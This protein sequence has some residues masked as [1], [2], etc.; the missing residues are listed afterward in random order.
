MNA[1]ISL[2]MIVRD[3]QATLDKCL[4][5]AKDLVDE[6]IIVDTGSVDNTINIA[7]KYTDKIFHFKWIDD[8]SAARNYS[9]EQCTCDWILWLDADD[10]LTSEDVRQIKAIDF[11]NKD[12][13]ICDYEYARDEYGNSASIVPR[14]R[15]VKRSLGIRWEEEIHEY[16]PIHYQ[17]HIPHILTPHHNKQHG[18]SERNLAILE[19]VVAKNPDKARNLYYLGKEYLDFG[20][21][22]D[23]LKYL[24]L[25][26]EKPDAFWEDVYQAYYDMAVVHFQKNDEVKFKENV[27]KSISIEERRAEPYYL[28]GLWHMNHG[29]NWSKAIHWYEAALAVKRPPELLAAYRPEYYTWLPALNLA[30]SYNSIGNLQKAYE[31]NKK[32]LEY[33]PNDERAV[34]NDKILSEALGRI[35]NQPTSNKTNGQ[36][37]RLNLG[38]GGAPLAGYTNV[39]VF[40][41]P[42]IDEVFQLDQIPYEDGTIGAIHSQHSLEHVTFDRVEKALKEWYR[43]LCPGGELILR[44]PDLALSCQGYLKA[45]QE[46]D[47]SQ[48]NYID[49]IQWYKYT[50]YGIQRSQAG[51]PDDAQVHKS[52]FSLKEMCDILESIGF[53][54][55]STEN[56][57]GWGTLSL[58][59]RAVKKVHPIK[60]G[61]I[62]PI[63]WEAAQTRIRVLNVDRWLRSKGYQSKVLQDYNDIISQNYDVTIMGKSFDEETFNSI[64]ALKQQGK[65]VYVD[66]CESLF[67]F[68]WFKE[69]LSICDKVIACSPYLAEQI[70]PV[71]PRVIIIEDAW[72]NQ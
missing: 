17:T 53:I 47:H 14:E 59:I 64:K 12:I 62:A 65:I 43:V 37:K 36:L 68:A 34:N 55:D 20:R 46:C 30:V 28:L 15:I 39:D 2:A 1:T 63:N 49:A 56:Y 10:E 27:Y 72:E 9:F 6:I 44:M 22:D 35:N 70:R 42:G 16:L 4:Q 60:I 45:L 3:S 61:W 51:E 25:F 21:L 50:I 52:G 31:C 11:S 19:R 48:I 67:E 29:P 7:K 5:S 8:F 26:V 23:A 13:I 33:R 66:A 58:S 32:V 57:N 40:K 24:G 69:I 54:L 71:N 41:G 18:T 38:C